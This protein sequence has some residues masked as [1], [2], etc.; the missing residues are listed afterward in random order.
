M[1]DKVVSFRVNHKGFASTMSRKVTQNMLLGTS[2]RFDLKDY[3]SV[4]SFAGEYDMTPADDNQTE[5]ED[6]ESVN[7]IT[8]YSLMGR[9]LVGTVS[10]RYSYVFNKKRKQN[11]NFMSTQFYTPVGPFE[12][13]TEFLWD[14]DKMISSYRMGLKANFGD[15]HEITLGMNERGILQFG[16]TNPFGQSIGTTSAFLAKLNPWTQS[17]DYK[18]NF[19]FGASRRIGGGADSIIDRFFEN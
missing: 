2:F 12:L 1:G 3:S 9:P 8:S 4:L 15:T 19:S 7:P 13:G 11:R 14:M 18:C 10:L 16:L 6:Y 17:I 5:Y